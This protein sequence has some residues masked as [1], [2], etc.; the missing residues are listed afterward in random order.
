MSASSR[1]G[2][3]Q[4]PATRSGPG[5][6]S[7]S[8][9]KARD[10]RNTRT[11]V[12]IGRAQKKRHLDARL[13]NLLN[14]V[15]SVA[16]PFLGPSLADDADDSD[17]IDAPPPPSPPPA[18][19][20]VAAPIQVFPAPTRKPGSPTKAW[21]NL[22]PL[23]ERPFLQYQRET[24]MQL[25]PV[26]PSTVHHECTAAC[27]KTITLEV[28]CLYATHF[29]MV[30][31]TTCECMPAAVLLVQRGI[32]P[33]SPSKPRTAVSIDFLEL[34]RA[35]FERSCDAITAIAAAL[36]NVY[37]RRGFRVYSQNNPGMRAVDPFRAPLSNAVLW[38][39]NLR[40]RIRVQFDAAL[41]AVD[42]TVRAAPSTPS[43]VYGD[44][45]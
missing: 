28:Q 33:A 37:D 39:S 12:G 27:G 41:A 38:S 3:L 7:S 17:W 44:L 29:Q 26:I 8:P 13:Q 1:R 35:L 19:P 10:P 24:H 6:H 9:L 14:P 4:R 23:L 16:A 42:P 31:V 5:V 32:F 43:G 40:T 11:F 36:H 15:P 21:D 22:L 18:P 30:R 25:P 34:Y 45:L 2:R 20:P